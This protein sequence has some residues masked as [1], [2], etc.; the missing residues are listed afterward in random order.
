MT[1]H[2]PSRAGRAYETVGIVRFIRDHMFAVEAGKWVLRPCG[3][4][5][6]TCIQNESDRVA[7]HY[8]PSDNNAAEPSLRP[9]E[10]S[11]KISSRSPSERGRASTMVLASLFGKW[12]PRGINPLLAC[13]H[14]LA[15]HQG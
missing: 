8:V 5:P 11:R 4:V 13:R 12:E 9:L 14:I 10:V 2:D 15:S 6:A 3:I 7:E 1:G